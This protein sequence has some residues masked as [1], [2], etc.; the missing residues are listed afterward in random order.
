MALNTPEFKSGDINL[1]AGGTINVPATGSI[2]VVAGGTIK[3][4][5]VELAVPLAPITGYVT[6]G[7]AG[8]TLDGSGLTNIAALTAND[9]TIRLLAQYVQGI[10]GALE[11][12]G[13][14]GA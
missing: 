2:A 5:G 8:A 11:M 3:I 13:I 7:G 9:A 6:A 12:Q 1:P 10:A 4:N 14:I